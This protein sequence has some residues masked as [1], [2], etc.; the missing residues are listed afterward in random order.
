MFTWF[1]SKV[2]ASEHDL[3][4]LVEELLLASY[5]GEQCIMKKHM[6]KLE[7]VKPFPPFR[8]RISAEDGWRAVKI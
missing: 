1:T 6:V 3:M 8:Y 2:F 7:E 4:K 5:P